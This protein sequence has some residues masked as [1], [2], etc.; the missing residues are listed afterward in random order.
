MLA[1]SARSLLSACVRPVCSVPSLVPASLWSCHFFCTLINRK[2]LLSFLQDWLHCDLLSQPRSLQN[3]A[4]SVHLCASHSWFKHKSQSGARF[5]GLTVGLI[6]SSIKWE[7]AVCRSDQGV[8]VG[9]PVGCSLG[10]KW[11]LSLGHLCY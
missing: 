4:Q 7:H 9:G 1:H 6:C 2:L 10:L 3:G 8:P 5:P 11:D